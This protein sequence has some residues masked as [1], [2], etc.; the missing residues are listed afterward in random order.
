MK[1]NLVSGHFNFK[2]LHDNLH[3]VTGEL[4]D[5]IKL[6]RTSIPMHIK[7]KFTSK[8]RSKLDDIGELILSF[9]NI[10]YLLN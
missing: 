4:S 3:H 9:T 7:S 10:R 2:R 6:E 8:L 1:S 5:L